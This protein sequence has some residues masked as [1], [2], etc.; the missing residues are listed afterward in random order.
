[1]SLLLSVLL[2]TIAEA[3]MAHGRIKTIFSKYARFNEDLLIDVFRE[4]PTEEFLLTESRAL[5]DELLLEFGDWIQKS[6]IGEPTLEGRYIELISFKQRPEWTQNRQSS[7]LFDGAHHSR[8]L[9][10]IKMQ[11]TILMKILHGV[12]HKDP[13]TLRNLSQTQVYIIPIVNVDGVAYIEAHERGDGK[14][15]LKRKNGRLSGKCKSVNE[16]VDLNRNY[17]ISWSQTPTAREK[18]PCDQS[19]RGA[20]P[21]S[22]P[23]TR[24]MRDFILFHRNT[25]KFIINYHSYGNMFLTPYQGDD[26]KHK[27]TPVQ[28]LIYK[29]I[30]T[31]AKFPPGIK[32]GT[33]P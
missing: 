2:V 17:D 11:L 5:V 30:E 3:A 20:N 22:E 10:T 8:E 12:H 16:G 21:W 29:E 1:M 28:A 32:I 26:N 13:Q 27:L 9:I 24:S 31:E 23:E 14:I 33:A 25:L 7:V 19:Y 18:D 4:M 15:A 6:N